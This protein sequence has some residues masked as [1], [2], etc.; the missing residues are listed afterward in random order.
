[1]KYSLGFFN[2]S[3]NVELANSHSNYNNVLTVDLFTSQYEDEQAL[4][5]F[6]IKNKFINNENLFDSIYVIETDGKTN[7]RLPVLYGDDLNKLSIDTEVHYINGNLESLKYF[8]AKYKNIGGLVNYIL[9][10]KN[11]QEACE[12]R[13]NKKKWILS[14]EGDPDFPYNSEEEEKYVKSKKYTISSEI[15]TKR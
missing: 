15:F 2:S 4:K 1:M 14:S 10:I 3:T 13:N 12:F 7:K 8:V 5:A 11:L 9:R 6:L